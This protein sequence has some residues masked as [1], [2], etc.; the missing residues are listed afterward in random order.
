[1]DSKKSGGAF[2]LNEYQPADVLTPEDFTDEHRQ[3]AESASQFIEQEGVLGLERD[4]EAKR[5]NVVRALL[6]KSADAGFLG[7]EIPEA[8][9]GAGLDKISVSLITEKFARS[10]YFLIAYAVH[11][12]IGAFP[13]MFFGSDDLKRRY[14]A[15]FASGELTGAY[16]LTEVNAGSDAAAIQSVAALSADGMHYI[17]NGSKQFISNAAFADVFT[18][19][20]KVDGD[21]KKIT[22]F[23]IERQTP[24]FSVGCEER[25]SG[26]HGSSTAPLTFENVRVPRE[27]VIG[28]IGS[29][30]KIALSALNFG[31]FRLAVGCVG[32]AKYALA[33]AMAYAQSRATFSRPLV[34]RGLIKEKFANMLMRIWLAESAAYR[35]AGMIDEAMRGA[36]GDAE[37]TMRLMAEYASEYALL[38]IYATEMLDFVADESVQIN[39]GMGFMHDAL[40]ARVLRDQRVNR[41]F[42][43]TNEINRLLLVDRII[44]KASDSRGTPLPLF[45]FAKQYSEDLSPPES[46]CGVPLTDAAL[47]LRNLKKL[48]VL[49]YGAAL[50]KFMAG[51]GEEQE[52]MATLADATTAVFMLESGLLRA[53]KI[54]ARKDAAVEIAMVRIAAQD[55]C[56]F[57]GARSK[58]VAGRLASGEDLR[59]YLGFIRRLTKY[60]IADVIGLRRLMADAYCAQSWHFV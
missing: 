55:V 57:I 2:L 43:G 7:A 14:L 31:R 12:G 22:A 28:E 34:G 32:A 50:Q 58:E 44:K 51:I 30:F 19:F 27:N 45:K 21:S 46:P 47:V 25:K 13:V 10:S 52:I 18:V 5:W 53:A 3:I 15:K 56:E 37:T 39:G 38:K 9:G 29:G 20:A 24:G 8:W 49:L 48:T 17:L 11:T 42:E 59:V 33:D 40:S 36:S 23:L 1:M 35:V 60:D 4:M 54:A 6:Q 16:A 41:I 26:L